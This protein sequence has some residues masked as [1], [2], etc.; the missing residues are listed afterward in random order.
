[1]LNASILPRASVLEAMTRK[2]KPEELEP[3]KPLP[4]DPNALQVVMRISQPPQTS[5]PSSRF[6]D[7]INPPANFTPPPTFPFPSSNPL[8]HPG[9][10]ST[11]PLQHELIRMFKIGLRSEAV[12]KMRTVHSDMARVLVATCSPAAICTDVLPVLLYHL[13]RISRPVPPFNAGIFSLL[14]IRTHES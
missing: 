2:L 7:G 14:F 10:P 11:D 4:T 3:L 1:M 9:S 12:A 5:S 6:S 8:W 13:N